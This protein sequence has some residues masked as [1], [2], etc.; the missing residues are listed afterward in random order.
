MKKNFTM[1]CVLISLLIAPNVF[2]K[3]VY[4][5]ST[6]DDANDGLTQG[7][8]VASLFTAHEIAVD[9][10]V[11]IVSGTILHST[12]LDI[13]KS[14]VIQ[15][16][17]ENAVFDAQNNSKF[18]NWTGTGELLVEQ[19]TFKNGNGSFDGT[20][21]NGGAINLLHGENE[22]AELIAGSA[23][24]NKCKFIGNSPNTPAGDRN[25]GALFIRGA[26]AEI[27]M[28]E[29]EN[30]SAKIGGA[31]FVEANPLDYDASVSNCLF[32]NNN[33]SVHGGGFAFSAQT[34]SVNLTMTNSTFYGNSTASGG[35]ALFLTGNTVSPNTFVGTNL[36]VAENITDNNLGNCG[37]VRVVAANMQ[38]T[39]NNCIIY[40][41]RT[42]GGSDRSDLTT[43][44]SGNLQVNSSILGVIDSGT[45]GN[46]LTPNN[47]VFSVFGDAGTTLPDLTLNAL[48]T[49]G[50][51]TY[52]ASSLAVNYGMASYLT[53]ETNGNR[54]DQL[55]MVRLDDDNNIDAGAWE[56]EAIQPNNSFPL[57]VGSVKEVAGFTVFPMPVN[58]VATI[59]F[60]DNSYAQ[61]EVYDLSGSK[62]LS[63]EGSESL[64]LSAKGLKPGVYLIAVTQN[65]QRSVKKIIVQ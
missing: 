60:K 38:V 56:S 32:K 3:N 30:N 43:I 63:L 35:G 45:N 41:N 52:D 36:T 25:G 44:R 1:I 13:T 42:F 40:D 50:V 61:V 16:A 57:P 21:Q 62:V 37:G 55:D 22:L 7:S 24:I 15:G 65:N 59:L 49:E 64:E 53:V 4:L 31:V 39:L 6:G 47:T 10:D 26:N 5:S 34:T 33:S 51:V 20:A 28:C 46:W 58:G 2:A 17:D 12:A 8:A 9:G 19:L 29:F 23:R 48:N 54:I 11:I 27:T 14:I 18:F